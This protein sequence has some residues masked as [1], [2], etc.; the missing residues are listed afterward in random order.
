MKTRDKI[1][2]KSLELFN[3][4]G[5][6]NVTTLLISD[7]LDISPG[8]LYYHFKSKTDILTEIFGWYEFEMNQLLEAPSTVTD[9]EDQWFFLHLIF[10]NIAKYRFIYKDVVNVL[11]RYAEIKQRFQKIILKKREASLKILSTLQQQGSLKA[12]DSELEALCEHIVLTATFWLN[13]KLISRGALTEDVLAH[14][15]YQIMSIVAPF[16]DDEQRDQLNELKA[17]YL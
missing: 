15:V 7:E 8:N 1:L 11:E 3:R 10:E 12:N 6:P 13:Y 4:L 17:E 14:G 16:L 2:H 5:E 9:I